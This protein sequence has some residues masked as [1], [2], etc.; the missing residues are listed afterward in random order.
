MA[1]LGD[2]QR[3]LHRLVIAHLA[4]EHDVGVLAQRRAQGV[5]EAVGVDAHLALVDDAAAVPCRY[6]I[7]SS[8]V[9]MCSLRSWLILSSIAASVVVLPD[10]VGPVTSTRPRGFS[11]SRSTTGGRPSSRKPRISWGINRNAAASAPLVEH[12]AAGAPGS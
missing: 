8:M 11:H 9:T 1:G 4:D 7:G 5:G 6:S 2:A 12:V 10:P 3:R